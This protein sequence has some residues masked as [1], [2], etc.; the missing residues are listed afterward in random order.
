MPAKTE[1]SQFYHHQP[2]F[3]HFSIVLKERFSVTA[4][5]LLKDSISVQNKQIDESL[6]VFS[7]KAE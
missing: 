4:R 1:T 7:P 5:E 2:G 6:T 3:Y